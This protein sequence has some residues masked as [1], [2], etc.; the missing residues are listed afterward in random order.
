M[1]FPLFIHGSFYEMI[2]HFVFPDSFSLLEATAK[3]F[4]FCNWF[5]IEL[6][7]QLHEKSPF[8]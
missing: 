2:S 5:S 7:F 6:F 3:R 1:S 4:A 8:C